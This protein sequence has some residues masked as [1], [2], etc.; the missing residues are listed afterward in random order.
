MKQRIRLTERQLNRVI[1][2]SVIRTLR[3]SEESNAVWDL[4]EQ[5]KECMSCEDI[6]ARLIARTPNAYA[7]LQDIFNVECGDNFDNEEDEEWY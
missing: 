7:T 1:K 6:L 4:L 5:M 2:E 3:E